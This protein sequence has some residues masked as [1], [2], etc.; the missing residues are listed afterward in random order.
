MSGVK[1]LKWIKLYASSAGI[2][3]IIAWEQY[4]DLSSCPRVPA[5]LQYQHLVHT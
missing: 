4:H 5:P 3:L 1:P 2:I